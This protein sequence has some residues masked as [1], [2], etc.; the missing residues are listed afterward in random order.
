MSD[1]WAFNDKKYIGREDDPM[2]MRHRLIVTP[3]FGFY[4]H[5]I[6]RED[7]DRSVHDHPWWFISFVLRG[8]YEE[9]YI[10][11]PRVNLSGKLRWHRRFSIH[12]FPMQA[13][14]K[15][16]R[17]MPGTKTFVIVGPK[18][19]VWGFYN[20]WEWVPWYNSHLIRPHE[21]VSA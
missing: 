9:L 7:L 20:G 10:H 6:Y 12:R 17:V 16:T 4:I 21:G 1:R 5:H 18:S 14:H 19:R 8:K 15:T 11:D 13:A 3:L 2:L